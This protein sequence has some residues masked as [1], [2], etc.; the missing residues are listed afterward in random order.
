LLYS[1]FPFISEIEE[2]LDG[3][4]GWL[5]LYGYEVISYGVFDAS[6]VLEKA[7]GVALSELRGVARQ[8]ELYGH[9]VRAVALGYKRWSTLKRAVEA[10]LGRRVSDESLRRGIR[11]LTEMSIFSRIEDEYEFLDPLYREAAKRL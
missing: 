5:A 10:W 9:I 7:I 6:V 8:S 4:P 11:K 2:Q 1:H 3:I